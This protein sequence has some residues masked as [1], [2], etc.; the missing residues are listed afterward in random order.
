[1]WR[2]VVRSAEANLGAPVAIRIGAA[3]SPP[4][5]RSGFGAASRDA[6]FNLLGTVREREHPSRC[7][8]GAGAQRPA[9]RAHAVPSNRPQGG[10][11]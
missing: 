5:P 3:T 10:H 8:D 2:I 7:R 4:S 6:G 1:M 11:F 9:G